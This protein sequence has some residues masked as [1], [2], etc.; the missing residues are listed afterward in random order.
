M[1]RFPTALAFLAVAAVLGPGL[2]P[3]AAGLVP[4]VEPF[5]SPTQYANPHE[6]AF[7]AVERMRVD[8][9]PFPGAYEEVPG[10][11]IYQLRDQMLAV[12]VHLNQAA[13]FPA[14]RAE[15]VA[16]AEAAWQVAE[17]S[18]VF[19]SNYYSTTL[20]TLV[21]CINPLPNAWALWAGVELAAAT[22]RVDLDERV[23]R[24]AGT[25]RDLM[26]T[27]SHGGVKS[28]SAAPLIPILAL[29]EHA[30]QNGASP[31]RDVAVQLLRTEVSER[32]QDGGG[33]GDAATG[34][35]L[36]LNAQVLLALGSAAALG[37]AY[38]AEFAPARDGLAA[39]IAQRLLIDTGDRLVGASLTSNPGNT[40]DPE[41]QAWLAYALHNQRVANATMVPENAPERLFDMLIRDQWD[42]EAGALGGDRVTFPPN[43]FTALFT[44]GP[45]VADVDAELPRL[46]LQVP[47]LPEFEYPAVNATGADR[48]LL[49][50]EW[51]HRFSVEVPSGNPQKVVFPVEDLGPLSAL[52]AGN[53]AYVPAFSLAHAGVATPL[54]ATMLPLL[55]FTAPDSLGE[56]GYRLD[57]YAP[58]Y[59]I[60]SRTA[61]TIQLLLWSAAPQDITVGQLMLDFDIEGATLL[62]AS[63]NDQP[64]PPS[65]YS[66][67][68]DVAPTE[69]IPHR[70]QRLVL[71]DVTLV[72]SAFTLFAFEIGDPLAPAVGEKWL[73][74]EPEM[75]H[76]IKRVD[77]DNKQD[78][79]RTPSGGWIR[80]RV[81]DNVIVKRVQ[82]VAQ[83]GE[84]EAVTLN[85][86][87]NEPDLFEGGIPP[88]QGRVTVKILAT[89]EHGSID[90]VQFQLENQSVFLSR[91]NIALLVFAAVLFLSSVAIYVKMG[92]KRHGPA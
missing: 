73:W 39:F 63:A 21:E 74:L 80:V 67:F 36:D 59:P 26:T 28:C 18:F 57:A 86:V 4:L 68:G 61:R 14:D 37:P 76:P 27:G 7:S 32:L 52:P 71:R 6:A 42:A 55:A 31:S 43:A 3:P 83:N 20:G 10:A 11:N 66:S 34:T 89:D 91:G 38:A 8:S 29:L 54:D 82:L 33:Y 15:S 44:R 56:S 87:P 72:G 60:L 81:E 25:L 50:N 53:P 49:S 92:R 77:G 40:I 51:T 78:L 88:L 22:Q 85:R 65:S 12:L 48:Y 17:S 70:H 19:S 13:A 64:L 47:A 90:E 5:S 58:V 23:P 9:G 79:F 35:I 69:Y 84:F 16:D 41:A 24:L 2:L 1:D 30:H 45:R 46:H 75:V 62:R